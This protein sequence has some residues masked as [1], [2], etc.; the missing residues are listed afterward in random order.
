M[1]SCCSGRPCGVTGTPFEFSITCPLLLCLS[2]GSRLSKRPST[3]LQSASV[4]E[5]TLTSNPNHFR[6]N[7]P[8]LYCQLPLTEFHRQLLFL[9][10]CLKDGRARIEY[11]CSCYTPSKLP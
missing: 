4:A 1:T 5:P 7:L 8:L 11:P 9:R 6:Y 3:P 2:A 10:H